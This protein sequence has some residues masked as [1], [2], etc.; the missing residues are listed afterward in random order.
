[1]IGFD[2]VGKALWP[3]GGP[4]ASSFSVLLFNIEIA[5]ASALE[6]R[7][8][9]LW[10][11]E[12][13]RRVTGEQTF[14]GLDEIGAEERIVGDLALEPVEAYSLVAAKWIHLRSWDWLPVIVGG[15]HFRW[16]IFRLELIAVIDVTELESRFDKRLLK[17]PDG[18]LKILKKPFEVDLVI[19]FR[20]RVIE[21]FEEK[22]W[23]KWFLDLDW[24]YI[25]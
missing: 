23:I 16:E 5:T 22:D 14:L 11:G 17:F 15:C 19:F 6:N 7:F 8:H 10:V 2:F 24:A 21:A 25:L 12:F 3:E 13:Q 1:M 9:H 18:G 20:F 4:W